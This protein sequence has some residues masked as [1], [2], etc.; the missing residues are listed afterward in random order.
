MAL[1]RFNEKIYS[2]LVATAQEHG[3]VLVVGAGINGTTAPQWSGVLEELLKAG[4]RESSLFDPVLSQLNLEELVSEL[5]KQ[6]DTAG[7][8]R[9]RLRGLYLPGRDSNL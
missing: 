8:N 9:P 4:V 1:S 5:Q 6:F 7:R 2:K 3:L